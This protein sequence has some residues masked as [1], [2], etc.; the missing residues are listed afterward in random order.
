[1]NTLEQAASVPVLD[2]MDS[3]LALP[4]V[5]V[6][7]VERLAASQSV[8]M[9]ARSAQARLAEVV[10]PSSPAALAERLAAHPAPLLQ[11]R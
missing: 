10:D 7:N 4:S 5:A 8:E 3:S 2:R 9:D 1:M 11:V 6:H